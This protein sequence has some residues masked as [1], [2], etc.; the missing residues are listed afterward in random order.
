MYA[1]RSYSGTHARTPCFKGL[2]GVSIA[3]QDALPRLLRDM[4]PI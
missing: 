3:V 2:C 1:E 4:R